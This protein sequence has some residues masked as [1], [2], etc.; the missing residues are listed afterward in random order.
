MFHKVLKS[1]CRAEASKLRTAER[2][3]NLM[4]VL[5]ILSWRVLW[6]AMLARTEP[7]ASPGIAF[8][9]N[10]IGLLDRLI[11]DAGNRRTKPGTLGFYFIKLSR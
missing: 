4:A 1:G 9:A 7:E 2:L 10:E 8:T 3:A 6:L 11:G 5:C